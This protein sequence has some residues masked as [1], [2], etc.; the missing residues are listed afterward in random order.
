MARLVESSSM[1]RRTEPTGMAAKTFSNVACLLGKRCVQWQNRYL[2][3]WPVDGEEKKV[4][5]ETSSVSNPL[6]FAITRRS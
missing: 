2:L 6:L 1:M 4:S 5:A 3:C